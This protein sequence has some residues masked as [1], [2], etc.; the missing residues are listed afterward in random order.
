VEG[1]PQVVSADDYDH[2]CSQHALRPLEADGAAYVVRQVAL[3]DTY[4]DSIDAGEA[5]VVLTD[6][7]VHG[8]DVVGVGVEFF[9]AHQRELG[10]EKE[11]LAVGDTYAC[12]TGKLF[13]M[14]KTLVETLT[15]LLM[16]KYILKLQDIHRFDNY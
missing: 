14:E 1:N 4:K 16:T 15:M 9:D 5:Q 2:L 8:N 12:H 10:R 7:V 11:D 13:C 6:L 3:V